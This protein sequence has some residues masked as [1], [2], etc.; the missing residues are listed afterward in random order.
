MTM[1]NAII[2]GHEVGVRDFP[3][4]AVMAAVSGDLL[5][6]NDDFLTVLRR[7]ETTPPCSV[8]A[9]S[10]ANVGRSNG[11]TSCGAQ[12][13]RT[14][15]CIAAGERKQRGADAAHVRRFGAVAILNRFR[16]RFHDAVREENSEERTDECGGN[17]FANRLCASADRTHGDDDAEYGGDNSV[18]RQS[19]ADGGKRTRGS[20]ALLRACARDPYRESRRDDDLRRR[21]SIT[22]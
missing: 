7:H 17:L 19:V 8:S 4:A 2:A 1:K 3:R 12:T 6:D 21:P 10:S 16:N 22:L 14:S 5:L 13:P 9:S 20:R 11:S 18:A 15:S